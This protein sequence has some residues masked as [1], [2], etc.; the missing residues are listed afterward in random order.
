[1]FNGFSTYALQDFLLTNS[2]DHTP[3]PSWIT[4]NYLNLSFTGLSPPF[5]CTHH[6]NL[7]SH[8]HPSLS[9]NLKLTVVPPSPASTLP[10]YL[11][12]TAALLSLL[13]YL[14]ALLHLSHR[15]LLPPLTHEK[16]ER[17]ESSVKRFG[18]HRQVDLKYYQEGRKEERGEYVQVDQRVAKTANKRF[19]V[20]SRQDR[21]REV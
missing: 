2:V 11:L 20:A 1:M 12:S 4:F 18:G 15:C 19:K 5:P 21:Y 16:V 9:L 10:L 7:L 14:L 17:Y 13:T 6:F 3:A 8:T